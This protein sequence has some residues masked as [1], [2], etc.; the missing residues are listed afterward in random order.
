M[1]ENAIYAQPKTVMDINECYFYHTIDVPGWGTIEGNWDLREGLKEYLGGVDFFVKR[2]LDVGTANGILCFEMERQ[3]PKSS[4]LTCLR[5]ANG[6]WY[7]MPN[8]KITPRYY[9]IA[10]ESFIA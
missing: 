10:G 6:I 8:G 7:P 2:V 5:M 9:R 3:G 1:K 4:L